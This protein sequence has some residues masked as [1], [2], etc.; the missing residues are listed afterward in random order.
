MISIY[1]SS[2]EFCNR[3]PILRLH[4]C[5]LPLYYVYT[6]YPIMN[7]T[8][9]TRWWLKPN[10][11]HESNHSFFRKQLL[12]QS[13]EF[14]KM[15]GCIIE[16]LG[17]GPTKVWITHVFLQPSLF[18]KGGNIVRGLWEICHATGDLELEMFLHNHL[19]YFLQVQRWIGSYPS[20]SFL[21]IFKRPSI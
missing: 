13:M 11:A 8:I 2:Y 10:P 19:N 17:H 1:I 4:R 14:L 20:L 6:K 21:E 15:I 9:F 18:F 16:T 12:L 7:I 3:D 5:T